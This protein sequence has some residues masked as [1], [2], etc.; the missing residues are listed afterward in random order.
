MASPRLLTILTRDAQLGRSPVRWNFST[1]TTRRQVVLLESHGAGLGVTQEVSVKISS[2]EI[3][4]DAYPAFGDQDSNASPLHSSL[5]ALMSACKSLDGLQPMIWVSSWGMGS[6]GR[7]TFRI[8]RIIGC[9]RGKKAKWKSIRLGVGSESSVGKEEF[10]RSAKET[11]RRCPVT[12]SV[13]LSWL[14]LLPRR[15]CSSHSY[16]SS[17]MELGSAPGGG[18]RGAKDS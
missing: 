12:Q 2:H 5:S 6:E 14:C 15:G 16:I 3:N 9:R 18:R 17:G 11:E 4:T 7:R 10:Q 1:T 8:W 13:S